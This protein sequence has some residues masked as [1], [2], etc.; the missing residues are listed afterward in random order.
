MLKHIVMM[1][2]KDRSRLEE[3]TK[4]VKL[5]L[6]GLL[7]TIDSLVAM[8]VGVNFSDRPTAWDLVLTAS[9]EDEAGLD[10]YR[11]HPKHLDVLRTIK[12]LVSETSVVD[13]N[14]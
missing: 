14:I 7:D 9:F 11:H 8:E 1:K 10:I 12:A 4:K 6:M 2:F 13:Y 5:Q 3:S